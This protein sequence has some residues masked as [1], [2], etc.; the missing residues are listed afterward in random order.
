MIFLDSFQNDKVLDPFWNKSTKEMSRRLWLP[1]K[2]DSVD[3]DLNSWN[4]SLKNS[5]L[6]SWYSVRIMTKKTPL[7]NFQMTYLQ[8]L[9][10]LLPEIMDCEQVL[11]KEQE[12]KKKIKKSKTKKSAEKSKHIQIYPNIEQKQTLKKWFGARRWIYNKCLEAYKSG[13]TTLKE[14][15]TRVINNHNFQNDNKWMLEYHYDLRDEALRDL[16]KN[17]KSNLE[18]KIK[19]QIKFKSKKDMKY[20]TESVSVLNKHWNKKN[21]FY[22]SIFSPKNMKQKREKL[23]KIL[24][25]DSRLLRTPLNEYFISIPEPLQVVNENQVHKRMI[26]IDPGQKTFLTGYDPSGKVVHWGES[27]I[28]RIGRLLHYQSKLQKR[29]A[30]ESNKKLKRRLRI[31]MLRM[32][33]KINDLVSNLH[34]NLI[35]W[36]VT[37]Y[38]Y[39]FIPRLNFHK[40]KKLNKKSKRKLSSY[41]HCSFVNRLLEKTREYKNCNVIEVNEAF[42]SKTCSNC[43]YQDDFLN[44]KNVYNCRQCNVKIG[45]DTNA[46]KNVMLRYFTKRAKVSFGVET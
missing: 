40:M 35:K 5:M 4:G 22:S 43:G 3:L 9:Q 41:R 30:K 13:I 15:R 32:F 37:N 34:K 6:N 14:L 33:K 24:K 25:Y 20:H 44:N 39:I 12:K 8:S 42:T 1:I 10:S 19:F 11:I 17:I 7:E 21:N 27:D 45:R 2:T 18:K 23:P 26:F 28:G 46:A 29:I 16:L 38:D 31:A 36:L